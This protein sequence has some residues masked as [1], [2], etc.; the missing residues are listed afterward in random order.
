[1]R[2]ARSS[3]FADNLAT[4][5]QTRMTVCR[6]VPRR[7]DRLLL[8]LEEDDATGIRTR[9]LIQIVLI[10]IVLSENDWHTGAASSL[11][12]QTMRSGSGRGNFDSFRLHG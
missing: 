8:F 11:L 5:S 12:G 4:A 6:L 1:V 3:G 10:I 9:S 7:D 2:S